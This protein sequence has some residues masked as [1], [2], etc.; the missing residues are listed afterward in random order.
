MTRLRYVHS[1]LTLYTPKVSVKSTFLFIVGIAFICLLYGPVAT[2]F[3]IPTMLIHE[4]GHIVACVRLGISIKK[5][6]MNPFM[7]SVQPDKEIFDPEEDIDLRLAGPAAGA[8][9]SVLCAALW[10]LTDK[11]IT[12]LLVFA[13]LSTA[14]NVFNLIPLPPLDGGMSMYRIDKRTQYL[15]VA[16]LASLGLALHNPLISFMCIVLIWMAPIYQKYAILSAL[17]FFVIGAAII[18]W[19]HPFNWMSMA[20][21]VSWSVLAMTLV[22]IKGLAIHER[23]MDYQKALVYAHDSEWIP[24]KHRDLQL[25]DSYEIQL[26]DGKKQKWIAYYL[27]LVVVLVVTGVI[28]TPYYQQAIGMFTMH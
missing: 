26:S 14:I 7:F 10:F 16:I 8:C 19:T 15:G 11:S 9:F 25:L 2:S 12:Q 4:M 21:Y 5:I 22:V 20:I 3:I 18:V 27:A 17:L 13:L 28:L 23:L 24:T 6:H 1:Q